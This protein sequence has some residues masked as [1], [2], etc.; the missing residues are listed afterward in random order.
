MIVQGLHQ[1]QQQQLELQQNSWNSQI[2]GDG[3]AGTGGNGE[4]LRTLVVVPV[5]AVVG[6][7]AAA[8]AIVAGVVVVAAAAAAAARADGAGFQIMLQ[9]LRVTRMLEGLSH[10]ETAS[11]H[12]D[13]AGE[14]TVGKRL[15]CAA[16]LPGYLDCCCS[17]LVTPYPH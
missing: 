14:V 5:L 12:Q 1:G 11:H 7:V 3:K 4:M 10:R 8:V 13:P 17:T 15:R 16:D 6:G 9:T 2:A